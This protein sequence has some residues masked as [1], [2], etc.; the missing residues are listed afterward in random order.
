MIADMNRMTK[1]GTI[2]PSTITEKER[3][4][5]GAVWMSL[6]PAEMLS[7]RSGIQKAAGTVVVGG[8]GLGWFLRKVCEK[9]SVEH[10]IVV[11]KSQELLDWCGYDICKRQP[12]VTDVICGD[13]YD[14]IH[15]HGDAQM[16]FDIWPIYQGANQD[17]QLLAARKQLG[18]RLW[19][20]GID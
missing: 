7:Q 13:I 3:A 17:E 15:R 6:T 1:T 20:W 10:V 12:K 18:D 16:L 2:F 4:T 14:E 19:A 8:L 9:D 5:C 11:E